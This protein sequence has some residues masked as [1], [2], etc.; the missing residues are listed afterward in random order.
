MR[1]S[2]RCGF[3][4]H[5]SDLGEEE[6]LGHRHSLPFVFGKVAGWHVDPTPPALAVDHA[7]GTWSN[8][9]PDSPVSG[10]TLKVILLLELGK[11]LNRYRTTRSPTREGSIQPPPRLLPLQNAK[12]HRCD[13]CAL[14]QIMVKKGVSNL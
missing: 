5:C 13:M 2:L 3:Y 8:N 10:P 12:I 11:R 9:G 4:Y 1:R 6:C 7:D 14:C